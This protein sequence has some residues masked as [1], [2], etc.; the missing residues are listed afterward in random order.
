[1]ASTAAALFTPGIDTE[2]WSVPVV[3]TWAPET[4]RPLTRLFRML[5]VSLQLV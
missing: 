2:I 4:P 1:M 3:L 5:T